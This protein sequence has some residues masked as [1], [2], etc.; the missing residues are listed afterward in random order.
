MF[1]VRV[2]PSPSVSSC[3]D[4]HKIVSTLRYSSAPYLLPQ[5]LLFYVHSTAAACIFGIPHY[6]D[7][8]T[9]HVAVLSL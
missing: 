4:V 2:F 9:P 3:S 5:L 1:V 6:Y 7:N 8:R